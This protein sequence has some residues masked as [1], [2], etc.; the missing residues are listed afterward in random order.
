MYPTVARFVLEVINLL[1]SQAEID[2]LGAEFVKVSETFQDV[3]KSFPRLFQDP[4]GFSKTFPR[5]SKTFQDPQ[6]P[7]VRE[8]PIYPASEKPSVIN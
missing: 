6:V 5:L 3:P 8:H 2:F 1:H 7:G 4:E